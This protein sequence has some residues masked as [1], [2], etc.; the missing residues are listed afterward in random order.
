[1][2]ERRPGA[3]GRGDR[4]RP[5]RHG[6][7]L[8]SITLGQALPSRPVARA[9]RKR[10]TART[11]REIAAR[12]DMRVGTGKPG[13]SDDKMAAPEP[14]ERKYGQYSST[15]KSFSRLSNTQRIYE[16]NLGMFFSLQDSSY[17]LLS[18]ILTCADIIDITCE[19]KRKINDLKAN[20][21]W[22]SHLI[23][24]LRLA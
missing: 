10:R 11:Q 1:M 4:G 20:K 18:K 19:M 7:G 17:L 9:C 16:I 12:D 3:A 21:D 22:R 14:P 8:R 13:A 5:S 2:E 6:C 15:L 23:C 24:A